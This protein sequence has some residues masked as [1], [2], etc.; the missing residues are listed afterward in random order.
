MAG[1]ESQQGLSL[2]PL[3]DS[4]PS[5]SVVVPARNAVGTIVS[6]L[7]SIFSQDYE[8]EIEVI[9]AQGDDDSAMS[10][11]ILRS[12]PSVKLIHNPERDI[13]PGVNLAFSMAAGDIVVRCDAHAILSPDYISRAIDTP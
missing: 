6:A 9:V 1:I 12:Y 3:S 5:V 4:L 13:A 7:D 8:G 11:L 10:E 2:V